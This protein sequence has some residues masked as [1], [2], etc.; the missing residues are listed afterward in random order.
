MNHRLTHLK[1]NLCSLAAESRLIRA[2]E[3]RLVRR[4]REAPE[5]RAE[6]I[7]WLRES[8]CEHRR[9][10]VR[11]ETRHRHLAY[12]FLRRVPY[13]SM[14]ASCRAEPEWSRVKR[15]AEKFNGGES[16]VELTERFE[17]WKPQ[18]V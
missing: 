2:E 10:H 15:I 1:I 17:A 6:Q 13:E 14:E 7:G 9:G 18:A 11:S 16:P 4:A 5:E 3:L 12:G 8:L